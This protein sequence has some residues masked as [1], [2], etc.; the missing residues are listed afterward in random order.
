MSLTHSEK[1]RGVFYQ[2]YNFL[3]KKKAKKGSKSA[4]NALKQ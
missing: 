3:E 2:T 4:I 1:P